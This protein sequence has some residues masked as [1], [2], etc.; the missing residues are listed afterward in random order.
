[1]ESTGADGMGVIVGVGLTVAAGVADDSVD[2]S[3]V[4]GISVGSTVIAV[5]PVAAIGAVGATVGVVS[6]GTATA[7]SGGASSW[8]AANTNI[9][10]SRSNTK[11][12]LILVMQN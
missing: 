2:G 9:V 6:S 3:T 4:A 5:V 12:C 10:N 7:A 1:M 11:F 8:Q